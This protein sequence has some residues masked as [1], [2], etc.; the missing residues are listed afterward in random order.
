MFELTYITIS[1]VAIG[2]STS[3]AYCAI[4]IVMSLI[5]I[6]E[7]VLCIC[8]SHSFVPVCACAVSLRTASHWLVVDSPI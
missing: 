2:S 5:Y 7:Y 6:F 4:F 8:A 3:L 1:A